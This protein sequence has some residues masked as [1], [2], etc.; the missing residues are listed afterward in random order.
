MTYP[1]RPDGVAFG[2]RRWHYVTSGVDEH[3]GRPRPVVMCRSPDPWAS[4]YSLRANP[5]LD[6]ADFPEPTVMSRIPADAAN[7]TM[8]GNC[9][10]LLAQHVR[11]ND[12]GYMERVPDIVL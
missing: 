5:R 4:T 8:C 9:E 6:A 11:R 7:V 2:Y 10:R 12:A 1:M 3:T